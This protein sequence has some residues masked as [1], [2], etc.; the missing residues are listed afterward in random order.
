MDFFYGS[1]HVDHN[2]NSSV[3]NIVLQRDPIVKTQLHWEG[4][5]Q[6]VIDSKDHLLDKHDAERRGLKKDEYNPIDWSIRMAFLNKEKETT[7]SVKNTAVHYSTDDYRILRSFSEYLNHRR[8]IALFYDEHSDQ[9]CN[10]QFNRINMEAYARIPMNRRVSWTENKECYLSNDRSDGIYHE[11][12]SHKNKPIHEL[13]NIFEHTLNELIE[14]KDLTDRSNP[15]GVISKKPFVFYT[16]NRNLLKF[17]IHYMA[18]QDIP[19][20]HINKYN[21]VY[22]EVLK[23][24]IHEPLFTKPRT[25]HG[26]FMIDDHDSRK[27]HQSPLSGL[28]PRD[29]THP[30]L[31]NND[32]TREWLIGE[33]IK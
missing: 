26:G 18:D 32:H 3:R 7:A 29:Y 4:Q 25:H 11:I 33:S 6:G 17:Y 14:Q 10:S 22:D 19:I 1:E 13:N 15:F 20:I 12:I 28:L 31:T 21:K 16:S 24:A 8:I 5:H 27:E 23:I 9:M 2:Y 30:L